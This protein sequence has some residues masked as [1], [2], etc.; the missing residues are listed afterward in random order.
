MW[1]VLLS[2][3]V[4]FMNGWAVLF[5]LNHFKPSRK[6]CYVEV[7]VYSF[8]IGYSV[9]TLV[10]VALAQFGFLTQSISL[11]VCILIPLPAVCF[12]I[13]QK[14]KENFHPHDKTSYVIETW[15]QPIS[16]AI[17]R[18]C[19]QL[20]LWHV[21]L[22][23]VFVVGLILR[24]ESQLSVDWLGDMDPYY[25]LSFI[26]SIIAQG[27]L[28]SQTFWGFYSYPPSFHVVLATLISITQVNRFAFMK[29]VPEF[30]GFLCVPAVHL[31]VKRKYGEW[32]GV[33]AAAFLAV[34]SFHI[35]RT[36]IA[37]PEPLALLGMLMFFYA[38]ETHTGT[39]KYLVGGLLASMVF[40]TNVVGIIYFLPCALA[41]IGALL[42]SRRRSEA[43]G[44]LKALFLG[45]ALSGFF[46]LPTLYKLGLNGIFEGLGPS[47]SYGG[48]FSF[49][50]NTYLSW[51]GWGALVF[52]AV[53]AYTCL[54]DFKNNIVLL[55]PIAVFMFLIEAGNNGYF[56]F[57]ANL[58]FRG[59][60]YLGTWASL[61][62]GVGFGR[63]LQY[64]KEKT[65]A[66]VLCGVIV[67]TM[68][69]FP[70]FSKS[71]YPVTWDYEIS[72]LAYRS[73]LNNYAD[74]FNSKDYRIYSADAWFNYGAFNNVILDRE[75]PQIEDA[76]LRNDS[77]ALR[78]L[79][80]EYKIRYFIFGNG[81]AEAEF[82]AQSG[83]VNTYY[84]NWLTIVL[85]VK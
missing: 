68:V 3:L 9:L 80:S 65:A 25:H 56:F 79:I 32:A 44:I 47:V 57:D 51:I 26:D 5:F 49:T 76:A 54:R 77:A 73:Y 66:V 38:T 6:S 45:A 31:V 33:A 60:L 19:H 59:L 74:I 69:S 43:T 48:A 70:V 10:G 22:L 30:L 16:D 78:N 81:T 23:A 18:A 40:L 83:F 34:S 4:L 58:L 46:W 85:A 35:Y 36:N 82:F 52:A 62:A 37:I 27:T 7:A 50:S 21:V 1:R 64:R 55:I 11:L 12:W 72:D 61:L 24:L 67:L 13:Y 17:N 29:I 14:R 20:R 39:K 84:Q 8:S 63:V 71:Q 15:T 42:L 53:G 41:V 2:L 28:P 75:L